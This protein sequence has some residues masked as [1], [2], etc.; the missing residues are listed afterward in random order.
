MWSDLI[1]DVDEWQRAT[2]PTDRGYTGPLAHLRKEVGELGE[3][4][5][6]R[7]SCAEREWE[8]LHRHRPECLEEGADVFFLWLSTMRDGGFTLA[9]VQR[10]FAGAIEYGF[11]D[12][13][14]SDKSDIATLRYRICDLG[15]AFEECRPRNAMGIGHATRC[16]CPTCFTQRYYA[17][18]AGERVLTV[19]AHIM[20]DAGF[21]LDE[22][23][24]AIT[25]KLE[26]NRARKWGPAN[27]DGSIEHLRDDK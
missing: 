25:A 8:C 6:S 22:L 17:L 19:W 4:L 13:G 5:A 12:D 16:D 21:T 7:Q 14:L 24:D 20:R 9:E 10:A 26:K 3:A 18:R 27:P 15:A 2:F 23:R 1:K 11:S